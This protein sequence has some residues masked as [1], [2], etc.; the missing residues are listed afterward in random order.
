MARLSRLVPM[1]L[2]A[3]VVC[4]ALAG[5]PTE[6]GLVTLSASPSTLDFGATTAAL[7]L[8]VRNTSQ[9]PMDPLVIKRTADWVAPQDCLSAAEGCVANTAEETIRIPVQVDRTRT[10]LGTNRA[11]LTLVSPGAANQTVDVVVEDLIEPA[12]DADDVDP[13]AG[14][15]VRFTDRSQVERG[16]IA[17]WTWEFG[18]GA[19]STEQN[20]THVYTEEGNY[21]VRLTVES[22]TGIEETLVRENLVL[23]GDKSPEADFVVR[24][25]TPFVG[26]AIEFSDRSTSEAGGIQS[27]EWDFDDEMTGA[28]RE[29]TH[30]YDKPGLYEVTLTVRTAGA[31]ASV[32]RT[33]EVSSK[34]APRADFNANPAQPLLDEPVQFT[35]LS[36]PGSAEI[37]AWAWDF[38]DGTTSAEQNP[39]EHT[40]TTAGTVDVSLTV[41]SEHGSDSATKTFEVVPVPPE[42]DFEA[43][44]TEVVVGEEV[45]FTDFSVSR[46]KPIKTWSWEFGDGET[47]TAQDPAHTY[48]APG[49]YTVR[50]TVTTND[51]SN[52]TDTRTRKDYI[53]VTQGGNGDISVLRDF[54]DAPDSTFDWRAV[55]SH[56]IPGARIHVIELTSQRWKR[57]PVDEEHVLW[58]HWLTMVEPDVKEYD[59]G[60]LLID[61]G[62][63]FTSPPTL[64][65]IDEF[66]VSF[67]ISTG[68]VVSELNNVPSQPISFTE[69]AGIREDRTEDAIIAYSYDEYLESFS[70]GEP[71]TDWPLL[72]PMVKSA[73][74]AMDVVQ[75]AMPILSN[76]A[77]NDAL[78]RDFVV[79]G[80]SKRGWTTWLTGAV[81]E[82]RVR[83]IMPIVIDVLNMDEQILHHRRSYGYYSPAIYPYAQEQIFDRFGT[84]GA[85]ALLDLVDPFEYRQH[86]RMPKYVLNSTGDQFFL[87]DSSRF[88]FDRMLGEKHVNYVPNTEHSLDN[89]T[90]LL[91]Q[92]SALS[93]ALAFYMA[94]VQDVRRPQMTWEFADDGTIVVETSRQPDEIELWWAYNEDVRDFRLNTIG[95]AWLPALTLGRGSLEETAPN[96][97]VARPPVAPGAW[98][99]SF[100]QASFEN[101]AEVVVPLSFETGGQEITLDE[102]PPFVMSTAV[103]VSPDTYPDFKGELLE[104]E[105]LETGGGSV[106]VVFLHGSAFRMG[107]EY[108]RLMA[109]AIHSFIPRYVNAVVSDNPRVNN[110]SLDA[111]W[112]DL[113]GGPNPPIGPRIQ[114]EIVGISQGADIDVQLLRRANMVPVL[115]SYAGQAA[116]IW[117]EGPQVPGD[118]LASY[119]Q[120]QPLSRYAELDPLI[121][122]YVPDKGTPHALFTYAGLVMAPLGI[123]L[124][125]IGVSS[126]GD[127][128]NL[129]QPG[130]GHYL[131][132]FREVLWDTTSLRD[133]VDLVS[134]TRL[135]QSHTFVLADG[136]FEKRGAKV[137]FLAPG[138]AVTYFENDP[139]DPLAPAVRDGL[140]YTQPGAFDVLTGG[141]GDIS[142]ANLR[143]NTEVLAARFFEE[144][145]MNAALNAFTLDF[146]VA[147]SDFSSSAGAYTRAVEWPYVQF[148]M[149]SIMP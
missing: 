65:N 81:E 17:G 26:D 98:N 23:V 146:F 124:G 27:W 42:A 56:D 112:D 93:S 141:F 64:D 55:G 7:E 59:T 87:P 117:G 104:A 8:E 111:A 39:E 71:D 22:D 95:E 128:G 91:D 92:S 139:N 76:K 11:T 72:F 106:P 125:G 14:Q 3:A 36:R 142:M 46:A 108:G 9:V 138:P 130:Y 69:E 136:R 107:R 74:R 94:V 43:E 90:N 82:D 77:P 137:E 149:Q 62:Q 50:L 109:D 33:I 96:V 35:D 134:S 68:T 32:T 88:Y 54:V 129:Y 44:P 20:P 21:T 63:R 114:Q 34:A 70:E 123:N 1:A 127:P 45:A 29:P 28:G 49:T 38:G 147:Y 122:I 6:S 143:D 73:V 84:P 25:Q 121:A 40:Y 118:V 148:N 110:A 140:V 89:S 57:G 145:I 78:V 126:V 47:S 86:L 61:G 30:V 131:P 79:T 105:S 99:A 75:E 16:E 37:T 66:L 133:A 101:E 85:N 12:F 48:S 97:Y 120:E 132:M 5:C 100:V 116:A 51:D 18:D 41:V 80:A 135:G 103:R 24:P 53:M 10:V 2:L 19:T 15:V 60:M 115:E 52:N 58:K 102:A 119:T 113:T 144:D 31:S 67:A 4:V 83:A 13:N